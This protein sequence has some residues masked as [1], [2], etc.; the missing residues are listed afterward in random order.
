MAL[1]SSLR[2][3]ITTGLL[4]LL[5]I[6]ILISGVAVF[7]L[8]RLS[9]SS[10]K[11]L[12]EN[13]QTIFFVRNLTDAFQVVSSSQL[14]FL[15]NQDFNYKNYKKS[16]VLAKA[17]IDSL[18]L[19]IGSRT[20]KIYLDSLARG[21]SKLVKEFDETRRD[22][23]IQL[24]DMNLYYVKL[25]LNFLPVR[26]HLDKLREVNQNEIIRKNDF[27]Q[28][29]TE[30]ALLYMAII[31]GFCVLITVGFIFYFPVYL[32]KPLNELYLALEEMSNKNYT[33]RLHVGSTDEFARLATSFNKMSSQ[34]AEFENLNLEKI[35]IEKKRTETII[36]HLQDGIIGVSA[37]NKIIF[38]NQV[39]EVLLDMSSEEA[40]NVYIPNLLVNNDVL[41]HVMID[42]MDIEKG[43]LFAE[44]TIKV[45]SSDRDLFFS[46]QVMSLPETEELSG[47][48]V[49][50]KN[51]TKFTEMDAAKT[52][53]IATIS[54]ELKT[55]LAA[56]RLSLGLL[57]DKRIGE[58]NEDQ[59]DLLGDIEQATER[60]F[61][62]T[63]EILQLSQIESGKTNINLQSID[64]DELV[65]YT[66]QAIKVPAE[67]KSLVVEA[68]IAP[69]LPMFVAD[70]DKI[71]WVIINFLTNAIRY[72]PQKS[73]VKLS[74]YPNENGV[75][76]SVN[77]KG[78]GINEMYHLKIFEKYFQIPDADGNIDKQSSGLGLAI[79]REF[80]EA[81]KGEIWVES[82]LGKGSTF[83]FWLPSER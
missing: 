47:L 61:A 34:I 64:I 20:E 32:T 70:R 10:D 68:D 35:L 56:T 39:A 30:E 67:Q 46:R 69:D 65:G 40:V 44:K 16:D 53:F 31:G 36:E 43:Q 8:T 55:P 5:G 3:R 60:L 49:L 79:C 76:F 6:I 2:T 41:Y 71:K 38:I 1:K 18:Y 29:N 25:R 57:R 66:L 27:I 13:Y 28:R 77:D 75:L 21:Y 17:Y 54:H 82:E 22:P 58:L 33:K 23:S 73:E 78:K 37:K 50:L 19:V 83:F 14:R 11:V 80:I 51:V 74:I 59:S 62:L 81:H 12:N 52:H 24:P 9:N 45:P 26:G 7:Y 4:F 48:I 72:A 15:A 42:L 63:G